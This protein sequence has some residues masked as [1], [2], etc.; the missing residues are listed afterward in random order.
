MDQTSNIE[1]ANQLHEALMLVTCNNS[2]LEQ[3]RPYIGLSAIASEVEDIIDLF[4]KGADM[5]RANHLKCHMGYAME[6]MMLR[7]LQHIPEAEEHPEIVVPGSN[8]M[9]KAHPDF[10]VF[11]C[12]AD[13]KSVLKDEYIPQPSK[14]PKRAYW[15][16]QANLLYTEAECGFLVYESRETGKISVIAVKPNQFIQDKIRAKVAD[17]I[18]YL[19]SQ[20]KIA[21]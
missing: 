5:G 3:H 18:Q 20:G 13:I 2:H 17:L 15:Q 16:M 8:G 10:R 12:P 1:K 11:G 14:L 4:E 7:R 19:I 9:I 21:A 6:E